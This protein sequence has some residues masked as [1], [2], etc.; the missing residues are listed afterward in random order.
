MFR[1]TQEVIAKTECRLLQSGHEKSKILAQ[2]YLKGISLNPAMN[3]KWGTWLS[4]M[5]RPNCI[6]IGNVNRKRGALA[7]INVKATK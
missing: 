4:S 7:Q 3:A 5:A 6:C 2:I 1:E